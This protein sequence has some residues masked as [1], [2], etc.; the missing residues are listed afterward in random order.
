MRHEYYRH[1]RQLA[2]KQIQNKSFGEISNS[3]RPFSCRSEL[4]RIAEYANACHLHAWL[5]WK[6]ALRP[7]LGTA[8]RFG[9]ED[10]I[11]GDAE[12]TGRTYFAFLLR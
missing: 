9:S 1:I 10:R 6:P 3:G 2:C 7:K 5:L 11:A 4:G 12:L 8:V